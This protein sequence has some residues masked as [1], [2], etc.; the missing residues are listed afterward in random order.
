MLFR[1]KIPVYC[2]SYGTVFFYITADGV[3]TNSMEQSSSREANQFSANQEIPRVL[4]NQK[5]H[6]HN[7]KYPP[8]ALILRNADGI[9]YVYVIY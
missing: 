9:Q 5:V 3:V 6:Y 8:F 1:A 2:E 4:W 7:H